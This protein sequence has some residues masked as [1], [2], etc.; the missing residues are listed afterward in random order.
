MLFKNLTATDYPIL[1]DGLHTTYFLDHPALRKREKIVRVNNIE[2]LYYKSLAD[3]EK[4][5]FK[6]IYYLIESVKL[7]RFEKILKKADNLLAVSKKDHE[8]FKKKYLNCELIFPFHPFTKVLSKPGSGDYVIYHGDLSVNENVKI[9]GYL[10]REVFSRIPFT[11]IIAGKKP[12]EHLI[13][14]IKQYNNIRIVP[15]PDQ[16]EMIRLIEDAH[17]NLLPCFNSNGFKIKLLFSLF[18]GRHCIINNLM[19]ES[20]DLGYLC[21]IADSGE[22]MREKINHLFQVPFSEEMA[23]DRKRV[24][25]EQFDNSNNA[26]RIADLMFTK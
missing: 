3:N 25:S 19:A 5:L 6:K 8:Y 21:L 22:S 26:K 13:E 4:N 18:T 7:K 2:H 20:T 15:D 16:E 11:C 1:F 12:P 14:Q 9:A 17:I 24:L 10:I 23:A